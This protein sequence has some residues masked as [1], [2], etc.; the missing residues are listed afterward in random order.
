MPR[1]IDMHIHPPPPGGG[2]GDA[3]MRAY[4][5]STI[6]HTTAEEMAAYYAEL[7][8]FGVLL[9]I[10]N[11]S[12]SGSPPAVSNDYL[13]DLMR[14]YPRQFISF[15]SVDPWLGR[16]AVRE[17]ERCVKELGLRGL[18]FHPST[19]RFFPN[20]RRF[21][22]LWEK[23]SELGV[24]VL[25]HSGMTGVGAGAP[26]GGGIKFEYCRPIPYIDDIAADFPDLTIILAHPAFPWVQEQLAILVHKPNVFMDLSGWSPRYFDPMLVQYCNTRM[27]DKAM[28]GSDYAMIS[29]ERWLKDFDEA[30]FS[31]EV[32]P[33]ILLE[34]AKRVLKLEI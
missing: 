6:S 27:K 18:K 11:R 4:F 2:A 8:I 20:D 21:Y 3:G 1:A 31:E 15:G 23:A 30:G 16:A 25:F 19:Q 26:G 13:A 5:R 24:P 14:R 17:A 9:T 33:L 22:P 34:N 7:D 32:R 12:V 28:F 29:P 10:D